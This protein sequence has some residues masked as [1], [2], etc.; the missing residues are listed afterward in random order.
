MSAISRRRQNSRGLSLLL[1]EY[2]GTDAILRLPRLR[3]FKTDFYTFPRVKPSE[4]LVS[5]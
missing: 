1:H 4:N 3:P 2:R 5:N